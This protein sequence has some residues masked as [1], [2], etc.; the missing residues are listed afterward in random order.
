MLKKALPP[1]SGSADPQT[2]PS[3]VS[4]PSPS[5]PLSAPART[6]FSNPDMPAVCARVV[7]VGLGMV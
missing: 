4:P 5:P 2:T 7:G 1:H 3:V 6:A